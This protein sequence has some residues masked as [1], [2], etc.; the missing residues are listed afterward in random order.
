MAHLDEHQP[1]A[2]QEPAILIPLLLF[3]SQSG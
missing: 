3:K 1:A 2:K